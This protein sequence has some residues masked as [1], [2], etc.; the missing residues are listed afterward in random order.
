MYNMTFIAE[1][2]VPFINKQLENDSH[3]GFYRRHIGHQEPG[4]QAK[5]NSH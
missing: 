1:E 2:T 3:F 5:I 4:H